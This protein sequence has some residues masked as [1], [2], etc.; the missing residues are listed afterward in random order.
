VKSAVLLAGLRATGETTVVEP[1]T[2]RD[3]TERLLAWLG[4]P[5]RSDPGSEG[6]HVSVSPAD[7]AGFEAAVPGDLS[8][9]A[10]L[11]AAGALVPGSEVVVDRVG[12]NPTR[13][14]FLRLLAHMG[15]EVEIEPADTAGPEPSG[16]VRA[17]HASL[18][19]VTVEADMIS[20]LIDELP[21]LAALATT[22]E[23][24]TVVRGATE[25]RVKE[26]DRI[27]GVVAGLRALGAE[28]EEFPDGF[29]VRGGASLAGGSV[30]AL[31]DHRL[32]MAF[33]VAALT[34]HGPV[35]IRGM[36]SVD[37]SFPGFLSTLDSLR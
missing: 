15:A 6:T 23:G 12:L 25:L 16:T 13:D 5:V 7:P 29:A 14:A 32:A 28:I 1:T 34:A 22:A 10:P 18:R 11:L 3:H 8:S 20:G 4:A 30:D 36:E 33:A 37:D 31:E 26:S 24:E 19:A 27:R 2:T 35:T 21:L 9:A 17:N